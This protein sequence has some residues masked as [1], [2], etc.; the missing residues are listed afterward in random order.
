MAAHPTEPEFR[1][2][3]AASRKPA[4]RGRRQFMTKQVRA[5]LVFMVAL[6]TLGLANCDHYNCAADDGLSFNGGTCSSGSPSSISSGSGST[7]TSSGSATA[8]FVFSVDTGTSSGGDAGSINGYTLNTT[9][10]TLGATPSYTAPVTPASDG[11]VGMVIAQKQYLYTAFASAE[12]IYG[13]TISSSGTLTAISGSP[14]TATFLSSF[15]GQAAQAEMIANP[16]GTMLFVSAPLLNEIYV[17]NIGTGGALTSATGSPFS[18]PF[19]PVNLATDGQGKFL[20]AI[21]GDITNHTGLE[22]AAFAI[23]SS[24]TVLTAVSGSPFTGSHFQMWQV[25]GEPTG[26]FLIGTSGNSAASGYSGVDDD[27]L[28]VFQISSTGALTPVSGSPFATVYSPFSIAVSPESG[29]EL[30]YSFSFNDSATAFNDPEGYQISS[31][32]TLTAVTG[33]PFTGLPSGS[34]GSWGQFDQ[35]GAFLFNYANFFDSSTDQTITQLSPFNAASGGAL[36]QTID[37]LT[38][39]NPG[40]WAVTDPQ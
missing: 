30:V 37:T 35:S 23:Q 3:M 5:V 15:G 27:H 32:G 19:E 1:K 31:S 14:Y 24:G 12:Q 8:A 28:Y 7:G 25:E 33:S 11:G 6:A 18:L 17:F 10:N 20:Y 39:T 26:Q 40:F 36:T 38:L 22:I 2:T 4:T 13:W 29:A 21:D 9:A 16:A 34:A